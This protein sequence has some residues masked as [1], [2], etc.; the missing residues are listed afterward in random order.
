MHKEF[1]REDVLQPYTEG[2]EIKTDD[3]RLVEVGAKLKSRS[4]KFLLFLHITELTPW[5][6]RELHEKSLAIKATSFHSFCKNVDVTERTCVLCFEAS[7]LYCS[8]SLWT[9]SLFILSPNREAVNRLLL[10]VCLRLPYSAEKN[11]PFQN[12]LFF[13]K[14]SRQYWSLR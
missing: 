10:K 11:A 13:A 4:C 2:I 1:L 5:D 7:F 6:A 12:R 14:F 8:N 3:Q 9:G